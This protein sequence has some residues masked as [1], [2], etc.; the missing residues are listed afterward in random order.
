VFAWNRKLA[1]ILLGSGLV[2]V[3]NA[4][5]VT[6]GHWQELA[7]EQLLAP[8]GNTTAD[9]PPAELQGFVSRNLG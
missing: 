3:A 7:D 9:S 8:T 2:L 4:V 6:G 5:M 1:L